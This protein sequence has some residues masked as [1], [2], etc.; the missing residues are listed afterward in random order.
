MSPLPDRAV[1]EP[2][3][4]SRLL[5][6]SIALLCLLA[7][8]TLALSVGGRW[9]GARVSLA[10]NSESQRILSVT[11]GD[12]RLHVPENLIRF[13]A[14]RRDGP[15]ERLDLYLTW[16]GLEGYGPATRASFDDPARTG[17]LI[18]VQLGQS[19]M[20]RDMSGR[21]DPV[22]SRL[23]EGP[24]AAYG[25]G[26]TQQGLRV[27]AGYIG[28][29]L[30]TGRS[31]DGTAYAVRCTLPKRPDLASSADCQRDIRIGRD[32]G[33]L[34]RFSSA[35]LADWQAMDLALRRFFEAR[36]VDPLASAR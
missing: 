29:T 3:V 16:P 12:D 21:L 25:Y 22:Y 30:L 24:T 36:L 5:L 18:F 34:Y 14:Q 33:L 15:A 2:L 10:G 26:L 31:A 11:L 9:V 32:L 4:S 19:I 13:A 7:L 28:E 6:R 35:R 1:E 23:T 20:S 8:A 17:D 27:D